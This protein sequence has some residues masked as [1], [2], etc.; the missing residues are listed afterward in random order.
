MVTYEFPEGPDGDV[1][2]GLL[3]DQYR[4]KIGSFIPAR[5]RKYII[6][7]YLDFLGSND[8]YIPGKIW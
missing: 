5:R 7:E 4:E 8:Y 3:M 2:W 6:R 1:M